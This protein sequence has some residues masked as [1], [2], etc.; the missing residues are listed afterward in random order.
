MLAAQAT[1]QLRTRALAL[2]QSIPQDT[3]SRSATLTKNLQRLDD[4]VKEYEGA[5]GGKVQR[6]RRKRCSLFSLVPKGSHKFQVHML[7]MSVYEVK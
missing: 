5:S 4:L 3:F 7:P 6:L 2:L 1:P